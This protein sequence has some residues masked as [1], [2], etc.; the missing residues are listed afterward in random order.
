MQTTKLFAVLGIGIALYAG[1]A[2]YKKQKKK[3]AKK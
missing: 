3:G 2:L 1:N